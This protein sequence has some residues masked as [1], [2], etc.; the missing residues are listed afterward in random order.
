MNP[1]TAS[2]SILGNV[3]AN[4]TYL[5]KRNFQNAKNAT[6]TNTI[7]Q[8]GFQQKIINNN[9]TGYPMN[10]TN[11]EG[12][13]ANDF[14]SLLSGKTMT[15]ENFT[16]NNMV[17]FFRGNHT[18]STQ[19]DVFTNRLGRFTGSDETY[20][21][22][23]TEISS[24]FDIVPNS[25]LPYGSPSYTTNED[26]TSRYV[27]S[28][29]RQ[30]EKPFQDIRVGPGLAAGFTAEPIGGLNQSNARDFILPKNI[31]ELRVL[32]NPKLTYEGRV[33]A[34][35]KAGQRGLQSSVIKRRPEKWYKSNPERG[36]LVAAVKAAQLRE[37]YY[38]KTTN[39][40]Y[41]RSY[42]GGLGNSQVV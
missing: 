37:K 23:K 28:Q 25:G 10:N 41:Q 24:F 18:Q 17:P 39:K 12:N 35:L 20:R 26:I 3:Y 9:N 13:S 8:L 36:N 31:D 19:I 15:R 16:H 33:I 5:A 34:G 30:G 29:K 1:S 21:P 4:E 7:P 40:Q 11:R 38:M 2:H 22:V 6:N 27:P 14:I 42:Y 32:T